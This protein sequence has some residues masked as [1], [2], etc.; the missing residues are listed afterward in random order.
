MKD[1]I[2]PVCMKKF[3]KHEHGNTFMEAPEPKFNDK[4]KLGVGLCFYKDLESL[5]RLMPTIAP[6]VDYIF[7]IDGRFSLLEGDDYSEQET[8]NYVKS[9][10]NVIYDSF[11]GMEHDKRQRYVNLAAQHGCDF[12]L[13][14]DSDE[15]VLPNAD[16]SLFKENAVK[17]S[18]AYPGENFFAVAM[19]YTPPDYEPAEYTSIPKLWARP[20]ECAYYKCHCFFTSQGYNIVRSSSLTPRVEGIKM[21]WSDDLRSTEYLKAVCAYQGRMLDYEIPIRKSIGK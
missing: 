9:F 6:H 16:W 21:A 10:P 17:T 18:K 11:I 3:S 4:I 14:T 7:A 5:K 13:I 2:C 8:I 19:L 1:D 15:F 12:L 20:Q